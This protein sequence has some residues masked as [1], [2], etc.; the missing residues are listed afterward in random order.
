[1]TIK[2]LTNWTGVPFNPYKSAWHWIVH[3]ADI[4]DAD[5][6][7]AVYWI[8]GS[9]WLLPKSTKVYQ[10]EEMKKF[11]YH[12]PCVTPADKFQP[13]K[14]AVEKAVK[15]LTKTG[16]ELIVDEVQEDRGIQPEEY[17][18]AFFKILNQV[19]GGSISHTEKAE[20][21]IRELT[22]ELE[23]AP[24]GEQVMISDRTLHKAAEFI[25]SSIGKN[26]NDF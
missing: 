12:G 11:Q 18:E 19:Q 25:A 3:P 7:T 4:G 22:K 17:V 23:D 10:P 15:A 1:M 5:P 6:Y 24:L 9:G 21:L 2:V 13:S 8:P 16:Y 26:L 20:E 14:E